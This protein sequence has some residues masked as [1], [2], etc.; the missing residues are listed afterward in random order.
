MNSFTGASNVQNKPQ[1][2]PFFSFLPQI[3][4]KGTIT[5]LFGVLLISVQGDQSSR[6]PLS[7]L[8]SAAFLP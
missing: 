7:T 8:Y 5:L 2:Q 6:L 4:K 3:E 1:P